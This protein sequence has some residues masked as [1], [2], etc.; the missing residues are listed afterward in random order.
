MEDS[1]PGFHVPPAPIG[2]TDLMALTACGAV[3]LG[4]QRSWGPFSDEQIPLDTL[5][6][7]TAF[8]SLVGAGIAMALLL[9]L[10]MMLGADRRPFLWPNLVGVAL[11][12]GVVTAAWALPIFS[13][14]WSGSVGISPLLMWL[15]ISASTWL[16]AAATAVVVCWWL[17]RYRFELTSAALERD[18]ASPQ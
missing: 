10:R 12:V 7:I 15:A 9:P 11:T 16:T 4:F 3:V 2:I 8:Y 5:V 6:L 14:N 17:R 1:A 13:E 18:G